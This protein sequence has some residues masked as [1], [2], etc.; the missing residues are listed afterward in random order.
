MA[1]LGIRCEDC[2]KDLPAANVQLHAIRCAGVLVP[3]CAVFY[4]D[5]K[6]R[7]RA[8]SLYSAT[9]HSGTLRALVSELSWL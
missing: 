2:G 8:G 3:G 9:L 7:S 4:Q 5:K 1:E 6:V